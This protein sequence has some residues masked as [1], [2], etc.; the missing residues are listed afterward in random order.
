MHSKSYTILILMQATKK[1]L[2]LS[3][4]QRNKFV[5]EE[6]QFNFH[7]VSKNLNIRFYDCEYFHAGISDFLIL[8]TNYLEEYQL[9]IEQLRDTRVYTAP[10]FK[11]KEILVGQENRFQDFDQLLTP[12]KL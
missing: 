1:W 2:A 7:G 5:T 10:Y 12:E 9:W 4:T 11:I 8:T 6:L 3:R